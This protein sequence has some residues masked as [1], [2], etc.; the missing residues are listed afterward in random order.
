MDPQSKAI[1]QAEASTPDLDEASLDAANLRRALRVDEIDPTL[2]IT[3]FRGAHESAV[4]NNMGYRAVL[5]LA[6]GMSGPSAQER[7][8]EEIS[9][10]PLNDGANPPS[11]FVNAVKELERLVDSHGKVLLHCHAGRSRAVA[12]AAAYLKRRDGLSALEALD[13]VRAKRDS[14]VSPELFSL[15]K[16][17][18]PRE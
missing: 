18:G 4:V 1:D 16:R 6:A 10:V 17:I 8:L 9:E 2:G 11:A 15:V 7:N 14:A 5:C 12:V 13:A 3:S